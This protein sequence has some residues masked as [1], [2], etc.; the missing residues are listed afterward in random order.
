MKVDKKGLNYKIGQRLKYYRE[1]SGIT[2]YQ[3]A[4]YASLSKNYISAIERGI[5]TT[6]IQTVITYSNKLGV[7]VDELLDTGFSDSINPELKHF[8][9]DKSTS[10]QQHILDVLKT[11]YKD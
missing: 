7:S 5:N 6:N 2:Q 9:K 10:E 4:E 1:Q 3:M 8:L 11:I